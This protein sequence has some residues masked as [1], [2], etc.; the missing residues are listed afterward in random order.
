MLAAAQCLAFP[1]VLHTFLP[2]AHLILCILNA[3]VLV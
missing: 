1:K 3:G 2:H